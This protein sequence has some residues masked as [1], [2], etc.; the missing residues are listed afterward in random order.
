MARTWWRGGSQLYGRDIVLHTVSGWRKSGESRCAEVCPTAFNRLVL[1]GDF[2]RVWKR[3]RIGI[4]SNRPGSVGVR[5]SN[6]LS[7]TSSQKSFGSVFVLVGGLHSSL[8]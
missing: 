8:R 7:S 1:H 5:G 2:L 6:P 3:C 4:S